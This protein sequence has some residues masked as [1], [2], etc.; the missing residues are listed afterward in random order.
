MELKFKIGT[1][2][3]LNSGGPDMTIGE[4]SADENVVSPKREIRFCQWFD[5]QDNLCRGWFHEDQLTEQTD[6]PGAEKNEAN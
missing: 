6:Y 4:C 5:E 3:Y 1:V 2:V